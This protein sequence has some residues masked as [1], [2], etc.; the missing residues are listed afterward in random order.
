LV[1][2]EIFRKRQ[3]YIDGCGHYYGGQAEL[4]LTTGGTSPSPRDLPFKATRSVIKREMPGMAELLCSD[5]FRYT[6]FAVFSRGVWHSR[7]DVDH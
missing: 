1:T 2:F 4:I 7:E 3:G 6:P 5:G